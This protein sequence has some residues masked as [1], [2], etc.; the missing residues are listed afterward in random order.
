MTDRYD[1][2]VKALLLSAGLGT[3]LRPLT[4]RMPKCLVSIGGRPL[5]SYWFDLLRA[6][7]IRE[8]LINTHHLREQVAEFMARVNEEGRFH[9]TESYEPKLLGSAGTIAAH[10]DWIKDADSCLVVYTDNLSD[11][12]LSRLIQ[13]HQ[14]HD[15]PL[16]MM[17]FRTP[18]PQQCGIARMND[19]ALIVDFVEKPQVPASNLANAGV[20][21]LSAAAYREIV[22]RR[23]FDLAR[24]V[25]PTFVGRMR[26]WVHDGYHRDVGSRE[27]LEFARKDAAHLF[28]T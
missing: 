26:G 14:S 18:Y 6:T 3:R 13:F 17:L 22:D 28:A 9:V 25:L 2:R 23:A 12:D 10:G 16:T 19:D 24:D 15:D 11:V 27:S 7:T 1:H 4:N 21:V 5:L 8:V 20:Y